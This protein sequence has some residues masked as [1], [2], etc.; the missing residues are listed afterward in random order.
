MLVSRFGAGERRSIS[1]ASQ[2]DELEIAAFRMSEHHGMIQRLSG[3]H[4]DLQ[5]AFEASSGFR[6]AAL[7]RF[8]VH[9][10]RAARRRIQPSGCQHPER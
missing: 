4:H 2:R 9:L 5:R 7:E 10:R 3:F 8:D 6:D 1:S